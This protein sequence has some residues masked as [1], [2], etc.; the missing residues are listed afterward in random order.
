VL[1]RCLFPALVI[2]LVPVAAQAGDT[3]LWTTA[4]VQGAIGSATGAQPMVW[5]E[6][7][8]RVGNDVSHLSQLIVRPGF[9]VRFG[10]DFNALFGYQFQQN[11]PLGGRTIDEHRMWQQLIFPLY[12]DPEH[13]ILITRLRL[14]QRS[15]VGAQDLGWRARAMLRMQAP[16]NG[17]GSAGPLLWSEALIGLNDTDWGQHNGLNQVRAFVGG[18]F[19]VSKRLSLE[20]GYM[21]QFDRTPGRY[22]RNNVISLTLNYRLG[23]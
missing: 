18:V 2:V 20:A 8:S 7:Q 15:I 4:I 14:E 12:R 1:L 22:R 16:L 5:M 13:L 10:P 3:Q 6:V 19:P 17:R 11:T 9:G 21:A 23:T